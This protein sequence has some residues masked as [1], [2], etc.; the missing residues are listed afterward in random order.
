MGTA[1]PM[2]RPETSGP[3]VEWEKRVPIDTIGSTSAKMVIQNYGKSG[4]VLLDCPIVVGEGE[5]LANVR[6][7]STLKSVWR[8]QSQACGAE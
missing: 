8:A 6:Q 4:N 3:F 7:T 5:K 2:D 1:F